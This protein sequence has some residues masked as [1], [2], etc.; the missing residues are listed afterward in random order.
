MDDEAARP[1]RGDRTGGP[2]S[3]RAARAQRIRQDPSDEVRA[4]RQR[5][6]AR[7]SLELSSLLN[8]R[9]E[10]RGVYAPADL[11]AEALSWSA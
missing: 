2:G 1:A 4:A 6:Q 5:R 9:A 7:H 3:S 8:A 11:V 10:L